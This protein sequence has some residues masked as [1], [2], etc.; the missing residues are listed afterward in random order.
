MKKSSKKDNI[1]LYGGGEMN[2]L[3]VEDIK[4]QRERLKR[5]IE[6]NFLDSRVYAVECLKEAKE[7]LKK[8]N[9]DLFFFDIELPDGLGVDFAK[10]VRKE[11][12]YALTGIIFITAN[13]VY[14]L[15]AFKDVHC[16]DFLVKPYDEEDVIRIVNLF[17]E[18]NNN[19]EKE[20]KHILVNISSTIKT[21]VY[22]E[23]IIFI[24]YL[25]RNCILRTKNG[26]IVG[27]GYGL[28]KILKLIDDNEI[29]QCHKAFALNKRYIEEVKRIDNKV[30][31]AKFWSCED[32]IPIGY[33]YKNDILEK[34]R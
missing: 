1:E 34:I 29:I 27:K 21:K 28:S 5:I 9:I 8:R 13:V 2:I 20:G 7:V 33:K 32:I 26:K 23:D 11:K 17:G 25:D 19:L 12:K 16:Y 15:E 24:E 3:V 10:R 30:W 6:K 14:M 18:D 4:D 22:T 31:E